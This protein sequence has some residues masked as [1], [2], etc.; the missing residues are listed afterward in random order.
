MEKEKKLKDLLDRIHGKM[1]V[2]CQAV[3]GEPLY[4]KEQSVMYLMAR[5]AGQQHPGCGSDQSGNRTPGHRSGE[6]TI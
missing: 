5:A 6:G 2:S 4:V 1:I 3:Q